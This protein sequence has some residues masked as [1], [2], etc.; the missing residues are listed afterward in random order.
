MLEVL[1]RPISTILTWRRRCVTYQR[2]HGRIANQP[3]ASAERQYP[4]WCVC[5]TYQNYDWPFTL[6]FQIGYVSVCGE[7][8]GFNA[9]SKTWTTASRTISNC[10][11]LLNM[12]KNTWYGATVD[13]MCPCDSTLY[14]SGE[15]HLNSNVDFGSGWDEVS[16]NMLFKIQN[17]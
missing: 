12:L 17:M 6:P 1:V 5:F 13:I 7:C 10:T 3:F 11:R 16:M 15:K 8:N 9:G 2:V 4:D 14:T